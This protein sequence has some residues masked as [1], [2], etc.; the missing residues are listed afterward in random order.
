MKSALLLL[1]VVLAGGCQSRTAQVIHD[2]EPFEVSG[3]NLVDG[4]DRD[5]A[6][7]LASRYFEEFHGSCGGVT[8]SKETSDAWYFQT[9]VGFAATPGE[10][11]IVLKNGSKLSQKGS[12]D[13]IYSH[14]VWSYRG[15]NFLGDESRG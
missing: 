4:V 2:A 6:L 15:R 1:V 3:V 13:V 14:G 10:E 8:I 5:E 11:I 9:V 12:P 7:R